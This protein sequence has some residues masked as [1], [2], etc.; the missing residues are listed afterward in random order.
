MQGPQWVCEPLRMMAA[1]SMP[2][3]AAM[4]GPHLVR[5]FVEAEDFSADDEQRGCAVVYGDGVG[6]QG[7]VDGRGGVL[8]GGESSQMDADRRRDV[9]ATDADAVGVVGQ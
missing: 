8:T 6:F 5:V 3:A 9:C 4:R 2:V 7:M 1:G